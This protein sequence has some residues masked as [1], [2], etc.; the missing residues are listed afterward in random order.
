[1]AHSFGIGVTAWSPLANGLLSG[2][3]TRN[4]SKNAPTEIRRLDTNE[5]AF[6]D[7]TERNLAIARAVQQIADEIGHTPPQVALAWLQAQSKE[8]I[9]IISGTN[10]S[11]LK[12][13]L[14]CLDVTL[15]PEHLRRLE[16]VS[17]TSPGYPIDFLATESSRKL[18][19]GSMFGTIDSDRHAQ[20]LNAI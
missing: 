7:R 17:Q 2:K 20:L 4:R 11:Q 13:N 15:S 9:P 14:G 16:A 19:Y 12:D 6:T 1:M 18:I 8:I 3:Y 10:A 5:F